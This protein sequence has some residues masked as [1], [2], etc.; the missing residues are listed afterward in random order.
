[1]KIERCP[2]CHQRLRRS[3]PQNARYWVLLHAMSEKL[4]PGGNQFSAETFHVWAK[5]KFLG[6]VDYRLPSG[7]TMTIPRSTADLDAAE[8]SEFMTRVEEFANNA[9]VFLEDGLLS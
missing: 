6:C 3:N 2:H 8:F 4:R 5:S 1:M 7:K 9:G